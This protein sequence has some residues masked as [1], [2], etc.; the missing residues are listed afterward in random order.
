MDKFKALFWDLKKYYQE[1]K[2]SKLHF[3]LHNWTFGG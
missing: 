1:H 3:K 2:Q